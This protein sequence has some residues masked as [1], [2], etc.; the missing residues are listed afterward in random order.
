M[1]PQEIDRTDATFH[2]LPRKQYQKRTEPRV[3]PVFP[4]R[5]VIPN[6]VRDLQL[7]ASGKMPA[8]ETTRYA[9]L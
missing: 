4:Q 1:P 3:F 7:A 5:I 6:K 2:G 9:S 8:R